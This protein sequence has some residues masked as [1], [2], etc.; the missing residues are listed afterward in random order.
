MKQSRRPNGPLLTLQLKFH[1]AA[2]IVVVVIVVD[3]AH[4]LEPYDVFSVIDVLISWQC[5][6][7]LGHC[8]SGSSRRL[9]KLLPSMKNLGCHC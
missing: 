4:K 7:L 1:F 5:P 2:F 8:D 9:F 3:V 6:A